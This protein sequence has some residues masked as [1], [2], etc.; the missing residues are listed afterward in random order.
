VS[1]IVGGWL[2]ELFRLEWCY[3]YAAILLWIAAGIALLLPKK[4]E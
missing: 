1:P 2:A 4:D 3:A